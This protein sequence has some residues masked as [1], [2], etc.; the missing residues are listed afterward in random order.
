MLKTITRALVALAI[1]ATANAAHALTYHWAFEAD[2]GTSIGFVTGT[3][4]GLEIG[5]NDGPGLEIEVLS[6]PS[7]NLLGGGW[8]FANTQ[9]A[10][11]F[12]VAP[13][14]SVVAY[15]A[16]FSRGGGTQDSVLFGQGGAR[17]P[18]LYSLIDDGAALFTSHFTL[19]GP[20]EFTL[21]DETAVVPVPASLPLAL[22]G[23]I[24]L[25]AL[26]RRRKALS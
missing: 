14:K 20:V 24:T 12:T 26:S 5:D 3:I 8:S 23:F 21:I 9:T 11:A 7:G 15:N 18:E 4:S 10:T 19:D 16:F 17:F 13:D 25:C 2:S 22:S 1:I 6:T